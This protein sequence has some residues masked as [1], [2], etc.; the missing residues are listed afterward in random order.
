MRFYHVRVSAPER[1]EIR[2]LRTASY[3]SGARGVFME[4][5]EIRDWPVRKSPG[6]TSAIALSD[7]R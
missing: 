7:L 2:G 4:N 5:E 1:D 6:R 3:F